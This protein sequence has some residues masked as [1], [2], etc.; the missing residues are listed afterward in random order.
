M[1][2]VLNQARFASP[3]RFILTSGEPHG[4]CVYYPPG[5]LEQKKDQD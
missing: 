1:L 4:G 5:W 3:R 2:I